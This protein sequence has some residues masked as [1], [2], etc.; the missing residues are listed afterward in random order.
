M[1]STSRL[2][3]SHDTTMTTNTQ[4]INDKKDGTPTI[5]MADTEHIIETLGVRPVMD[6]EHKLLSESIQKHYNIKSKSIYFH[7]PAIH[8]FTSYMK[9]E[10]SLN[11]TDR[12]ISLVK[13]KERVDCIGFF[14]RAKIKTARRGYYHTDIFAKE[15][16]ILP[17]H[18]AHLYYKRDHLSPAMEQVLYNFIYHNNSAITSEIMCSYLASKLRELDISPH[19]CKMYGCVRMVL[20]RFTYNITS[21]SEFKD[22]SY[23]RDF[24]EENESFCEFV[25]RRRKLFLE[26]RDFPCYL[27]MCEKADTDI[28]LLYDIGKLDETHFN[29][30]VFQIYAAIFCAISIFGL[31]HNDLHLSNVMLSRTKQKYLYYYYKGDYYRIP[32]FGY[33]VRIIDWGRGTYEFDGNQGYNHIFT[34]EYDCF[35]QYRYK[36]MNHSGLEPILPSRQKWTDIVMITHNILNAWKGFRN[37][38]LGKSMKKWIENKD[39]VPLDI[40]EFNW[41]IYCGVTQHTYNVQPHHILQHRSFRA[42]VVKQLDIPDGSTVYPLMVGRESVTQRLKK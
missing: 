24:I 25:T 3:K 27:L 42:F 28:D 15:I 34:T 39:G 30:I 13:K 33:I 1:V 7:N 14:Y 29:S 19:F 40:D 37:T 8:L 20:D 36:R 18:K 12:I 35:D 11:H 4:T 38:E 10:K 17:V 21:D 26:Y 31:K 6:K 2:E 23:V 5:Q 41:E 22:E 32:T 16:P 9:Y